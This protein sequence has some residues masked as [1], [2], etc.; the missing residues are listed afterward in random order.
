M[1][2]AH[3]QV[4][5]SFAIP[6]LMVGFAG[7]YYHFKAAANRKPG[8]RVYDLRGDN[9]LFWDRNQFTDAGRKYLSWSYTCVLVFWTLVVLA[10]LV[11]K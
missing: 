7:F 9:M 5:L 1:I 8:V 11:G 2:A 6:A 10:A 4:S 3:Q